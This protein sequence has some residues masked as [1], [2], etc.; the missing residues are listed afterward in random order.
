MTDRD[1][2]RV[3]DQDECIEEIIRLRDALERIADDNDATDL[4]ECKYFA[5]EAL[6]DE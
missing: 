5:R 1:Y 6:G 3:R 4:G 2:W